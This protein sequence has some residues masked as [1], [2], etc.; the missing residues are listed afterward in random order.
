MSGV[1]VSIFRW[2]A[3]NGIKSCQSHYSELLLIYL[4]IIEYCNFFSVGSEA[5]LGETRSTLLLPCRYLQGI[6]S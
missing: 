4:R 2:D 3:C 6:S 5:E 1:E